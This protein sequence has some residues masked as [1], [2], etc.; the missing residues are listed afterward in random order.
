MSQNDVI[1][2]SQSH[3]HDFSVL[4]IHSLHNHGNQ[5]MFG[6]IVIFQTF[7]MLGEITK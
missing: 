3:C 2:G 7:P 5:T 6:L 1:I 4:D